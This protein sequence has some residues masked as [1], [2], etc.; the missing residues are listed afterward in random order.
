MNGQ[1]ANLVRVVTA[2]GG[3]PKAE[4]DQLLARLKS[5]E[6]AQELVDRMSSLVKAHSQ[7]TTVPPTPAQGSA[8][9]RGRPPGKKKKK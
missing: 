5:S 1:Y 9:R 4:L 7:S 3:K 2:I 6:G 8:K